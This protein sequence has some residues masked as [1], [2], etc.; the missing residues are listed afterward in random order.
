MILLWRRHDEENSSST[1]KILMIIDEV[2]K[3]LFCEIYLA[4]IQGN[5]HEIQYFEFE[6]KKKK[7]IKFFFELLMQACGNC[8][9]IN[10]KEKFEKNVMDT[11]EKFEKLRN[12]A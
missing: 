6:N 5:Y 4:P 3:S 10:E 7:E 1:E 8:I 2:K 12:F 11:L 9:Y